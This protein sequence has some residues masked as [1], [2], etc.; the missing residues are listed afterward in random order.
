LIL[1]LLTT[2]LVR[3]AKS[4][5]LASLGVCVHTTRVLIV[6]SIFATFAWPAISPA[7]V[8][9]TILGFRVVVQLEWVLVIVRL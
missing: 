5:A 4:V 6:T 1:A 3:V 8:R 9:G 2:R 7:R